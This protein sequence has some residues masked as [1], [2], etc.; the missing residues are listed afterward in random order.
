MVQNFGLDECFY[1]VISQQFSR[2]VYL[3]RQT[4]IK[5]PE[6]HNEIPLRHSEENIA[7]GSLVQNR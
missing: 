2:F 5:K 6:K 1:L 7:K 3:K 4:A